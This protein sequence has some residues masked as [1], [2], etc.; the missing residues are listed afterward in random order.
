MDT[1]PP[2]PTA[3]GDPRTDD[4]ALGFLLASAHQAARGALSDELRP[5]GIE[6]RHSAVLSALDRLGPTSQRRLG[7]LLGLDKSAVVR[8]MDE[9]ER[10]GLAV[11]NRS[12]HD[13]RAYAI[14][15]TAEGRRRARSSAQTA[16]AVGER[17]FGWLSPAT[18]NGSS[19]CS[20]ASRNARRPLRPAAKPGTPSPV[21]A[22]PRQWPVIR[23]ARRARD[24]VR[25]D[26]ADDS[27]ASAAR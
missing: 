5:L 23:S 3:L 21:R 14:E 1:Q 4:A 19:R 8:I 16:G 17:L 7:A 18:A 13:R 11:R 27:R 22:A 9:L 12:A 10:L 24:D 20:P 25:A 2:E 26:P 6:T 15:L